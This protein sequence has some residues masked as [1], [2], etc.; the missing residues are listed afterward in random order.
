[1][2]GRARMPTPAPILPAVPLTACPIRATIG[3]L[4][5]KWSLLILRDIAFFRRVSFG[6]I[7]RSYPEITPRVLSMRLRELQKD[8][9]I[10][11]VA[12]PGKPR[13]VRYRLTSEGSDVL[14]ILTAYFQ[15]GI[16]HHAARVFPDRSP[17]ELEEV[18]PSDQVD[19]LGRL[20]EYAH[21]AGDGVDRRP[22][23]LDDARPSADAAPNRLPTRRTRTSA[24]G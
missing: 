13:R 1:M 4:G 9:I 3:T 21:T 12:D 6:A 23:V 24:P 19:L 11:R 17:R 20:L 10:E 5:H 22:V 16:R 2:T 14:P 18:F 8:G 15:Y 7:R